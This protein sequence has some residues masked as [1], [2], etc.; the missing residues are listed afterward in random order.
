MMV[1]EEDTPAFRRRR[2]AVKPHSAEVCHRL[3]LFNAHTLSGSSLLDLLQKK[4][5]VFQ[6]NA[7]LW[8]ERRDLNPHELLVIHKN[9]NLARLPISPLSQIDFK[10]LS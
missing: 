1:R 4:H 10:I 3:T 8:C 5:P 6:R 7:L 9:L 2:L